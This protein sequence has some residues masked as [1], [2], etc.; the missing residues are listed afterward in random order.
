[1]RRRALIALLVITAVMAAGTREGLP[2]IGP[3]PA[4]TLTTQEN[5]RLSLHECSGR[6]A[7]GRTSSTSRPIPQ[8]AV[9]GLEG[10]ALALPGIVALSHA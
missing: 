2:Q 8:G 9:T 4:F 10:T 3:A 7:G 1:V 5:K 6:D